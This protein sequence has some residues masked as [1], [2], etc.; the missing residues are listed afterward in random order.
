MNWQECELVKP[1]LQLPIAIPVR[2]QR[3]SLTSERDAIRF[4]NDSEIFCD[5]GRCSYLLQ[6]T[7][8]SL[9]PRC[10]SLETVS[11]IQG[12][13][14]EQKVCHWIFSACN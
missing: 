12:V 1:D 7:G 11:Q 3:V 13:V 2:C 9:S 5:Y 6:L 4:D 10:S 8:F 14:A